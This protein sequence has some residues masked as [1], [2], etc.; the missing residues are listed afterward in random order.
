MLHA[1]LARSFDG[2]SGPFEKRDAVV[3][4]VIADECRRGPRRTL[5]APKRRRTVVES[6][7]KYLPIP[8]EH[9]VHVGGIE[10]EVLQFQAKLGLNIGSADTCY[11]KI[12]SPRYEAR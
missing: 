12:L 6:H 7:A 11:P 8:V 4:L 2:R 5:R 10:A 9:G 3:H 1:L